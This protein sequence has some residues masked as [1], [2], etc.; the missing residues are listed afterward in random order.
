MREAAEESRGF[1]VALGGPGAFPREDAP[2]ALWLG[3]DSGAPDLERLAGRVES[4]LVARGWQREGRP[5]R[6]HLT[7]AR[8]DDQAAGRN[9]LA[10]VRAAMAVAGP[11]LRRAWPADE[12]ALFESHLGRGPARYEAL[13]TARLRA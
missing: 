9:A 2:R 7:L 10:W 6:A 8:S 3:L 11:D 5:F 12:V 4:A 1:T 13:T